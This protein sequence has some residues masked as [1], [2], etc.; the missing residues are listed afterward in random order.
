MDEL[1][2]WYW[3]TLLHLGAPAAE[4]AS[5]GTLACALDRAVQSLSAP[6]VLVYDCAGLSAK[7]LQ[8]LLTLWSSAR[9]RYRGRLG[10]RIALP[11]HWTDA[12]RFTDASK[13]MWH[14]R[15]GVLEISVEQGST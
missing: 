12:L 7:R 3:H 6:R 1:Q 8:H 11:P 9:I 15:N 4:T 13:L 10:C 2:F 5:I 14:V